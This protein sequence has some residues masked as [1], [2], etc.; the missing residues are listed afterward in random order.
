[1]KRK[2]TVLLVALLVAGVSLFA[3]S[4]S[5][6]YQNFSDAI[7]NGDV[8]LAID[9]YTQLQEQT[10]KEIQKAQRSYEKALQAG[11]VQR[12]INARNDYYGISRYTMSEEDTDA[13]LSLIL[14]EDSESAIEHAKWLY[15]NSSYYYP[16]LSYEWKSSSDSFS[17]SYSRSVTVEPGITIT[18]PTADN[19]GIDTSMAGVLVGWGITPDEVTYAAGETISAPLTSQTLYAIWKT[20]VRFTDSVTGT[21][22]VVDDVAAGD[23]VAVPQLTAPDD[24]YVFAG[25]VDESTGVYLSPD[26]NEYIL[27]G[28]GAVFT[29]LWKK[30]DI[31]G[32]EGRHYDIA[33]LPVNT[34]SELSFTVSNAGTEDLR[35]LSVEVTGN[36]G[37]SVLSGNGRVSYLRDGS[38]ITMTGLDVVA[39]TAGEHTLTVTITDRDG[40]SWSAAFT[41]NAQ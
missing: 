4:A 18:L 39:T 28:N 27:E 30:L 9:C 16:T 1:M 21:E 3:A 23:S 8:N 38:S 40:D 41:V 5:E 11:N 36:D 25:W 20:E 32:L 15:S 19:V 10:G 2:F 35:N 31:S 33:S 17:Y 13:L 6:L 34:Q 26:D 7:S 24:A 22:S 14:K 29:A 37:L 12:A